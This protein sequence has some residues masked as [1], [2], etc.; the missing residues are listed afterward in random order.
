MKKQLLLLAMACSG[1]VVAEG[2]TNAQNNQM[3]E[4]ARSIGESMQ[5]MA[6]A[7]AARQLRSDCAAEAVSALKFLMQSAVFRGLEK[8]KTFDQCPRFLVVS[9]I[10]AQNSLVQK[11]TEAARLRKLCGDNTITPFKLGP[12]YKDD[13]KIR[14]VANKHDEQVAKHLDEGKTA[15]SEELVKTRQELEWE[16][17]RYHFDELK[18]SAEP[19][20]QQPMAANQPKAVPA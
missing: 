15:P 5:K 7:V 17:I 20:Q 4:A 9:R 1:A 3:I 13:A 18:Q 2:L 6:L 11:L 12:V 14:E 10:Y 16:V 8:G 19:T